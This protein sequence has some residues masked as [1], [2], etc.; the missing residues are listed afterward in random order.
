[1]GGCPSEI[2]ILSQIEEFF[3]ILSKKVEKGK[4][5]KVLGVGVGFESSERT[6]A[7]RNC[8][9]AALET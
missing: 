2:W 5:F 3:W 9:S 7:F 4:G 8:V 1:M 6:R